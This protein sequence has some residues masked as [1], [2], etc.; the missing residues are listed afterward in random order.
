MMNPM[1]KKAMDGIMKDLLKHP[2]SPPKSKMAGM[3]TAAHPA[4][5]TITIA[6][7][8]KSPEGSPEEEEMESPDIEKSEDG[9][10]EMMDPMTKMKHAKEMAAMHAKKKG[11]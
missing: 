10:P 7:G 4:A 8:M 5:M 3:P 1:R 11:Y 6:H 9:A 2:M